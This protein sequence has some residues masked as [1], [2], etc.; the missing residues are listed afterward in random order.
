MFE[1]VK[2]KLMIDWRNCYLIQ[3]Y[4]QAFQQF[5]NVI[6]TSAIEKKILRGILEN[7]TYENFMGQLKNWFK[8]GRYVWYICGN[9]Q[10]D[11][12]I[13]LVE[14]CRAKLDLQTI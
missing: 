11:E 8:K 5:Q 9:Y 12:A 10:H 14:N 7:Y 13:K 3:S 2:E 1:Q 4:Q 6:Y